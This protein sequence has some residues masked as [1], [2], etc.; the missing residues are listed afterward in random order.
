MSSKITKLAVDG[1]EGIETNEVISANHS[2]KIQDED[3]GALSDDDREKARDPSR[4]RKRDFEEETIEVD[5]SLPEPPSKKAQRKA[6]KGKKERTVDA[7]T[8]IIED[9]KLPEPVKDETPNANKGVDDDDTLMQ[10]KAKAS[11]ATH[12]VWVGNLPFAATKTML[13]DFFTTNSEPRI[14]KEAITRIHMPAPSNAATTREKMKPM[15]KGFA[16]VD[17]ANLEAFTAAL[18]L[19][20]TLLGSRNL[21]IKNAK[22]FE[23]RPVE[24]EKQVKSSISKTASHRIFVGNLGFDVTHEELSSFFGVCGTIENLHVATFQDTGKCKGYAWITFADVAAAKDAVRGWTHVA[25]EEDS[26]ADEVD[27]EAQPRKT[28]KRQVFCNRLQGREIRRE[29]AEDPKTRYNK[30]FGKKAQSNADYDQSPIAEVAKNSAAPLQEHQR[31]AGKRQSTE[32]QPGAPTDLNKRRGRTHY[33][34]GNQ[35][36]SQGMRERTQYRRGQMTEGTGTK[37]TFD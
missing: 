16:Y 2:V 4:K 18:A 8:T 11:K 28:K 13:T 3:V 22:N 12:S 17:F 21:L 36:T 24:H 32:I 31:K 34:E 26:G 29:F 1:E 20:E 6:K 10:S 7:S 27:D 19:T 9:R 5:L 15:N 35:G 37:V 33:S 30:R 25:K 14:G 23:G